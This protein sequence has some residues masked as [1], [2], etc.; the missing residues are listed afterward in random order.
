MK[1][2]RR[3]R[4]T[5]PETTVLRQQIKPK[6]SKSPPS[7]WK[8]VITTIKKFFAPNAEVKTKHEDRRAEATFL[9]DE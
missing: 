9:P 2:R 8:A 1:R 7:G 6:R 3:G 5:R 4:R